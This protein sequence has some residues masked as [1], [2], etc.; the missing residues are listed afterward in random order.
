MFNNPWHK[1]LSYAVR[2]PLNDVRRDAVLESTGKSVTASEYTSTR[3]TTALKT[4]VFP[5]RLLFERKCPSPNQRSR[6]SVHS[7]CVDVSG[8]SASVGQ[9]SQTE[10]EN[11]SYFECP[12]TPGDRLKTI[13]AKTYARGIL[14]CVGVR[15]CVAHAMRCASDLGRL[16]VLT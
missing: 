15:L 9:E 13:P 12:E 11:A 1:L 3:I 8:A 2:E 14:C 10:N 5:T 4:A 16:G 6:V 7:P